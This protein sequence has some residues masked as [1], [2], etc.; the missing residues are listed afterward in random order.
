MSSSVGGFA[1]DG[2][3]SLDAARRVQQVEVELVT[4]QAAVWRRSV[5]FSSSSSV[6]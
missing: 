6:G 4:L 2:G 5:T 3:R 1:G